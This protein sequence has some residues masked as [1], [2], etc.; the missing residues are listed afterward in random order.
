[1]AW[2]LNLGFKPFAKNTACST[3]SNFMIQTKTSCFN[4]V[5]FL[6]MFKIKFMQLYGPFLI[7]LDCFVSH[8]VS[9]TTLT[10]QTK[11]MKKCVSLLLWDKP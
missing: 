4:L 2:L 3:N 7:F 5:M 9:V 11:C 8:V 10:S 1:M 6:D